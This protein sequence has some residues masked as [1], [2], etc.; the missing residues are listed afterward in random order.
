MVQHP[1]VEIYRSMCG[2]KEKNEMLTTYGAKYLMIAGACL[3]SM[4]VL[5]MALAGALPPHRYGWFA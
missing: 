5:G 2:S 4:L 1:D 3:A